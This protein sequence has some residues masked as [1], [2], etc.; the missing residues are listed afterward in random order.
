MTS[1]VHITDNRASTHVALS[2]VDPEPDQTAVEI[3]SLWWLRFQRCPNPRSALIYYMY[4]NGTQGVASVSVSTFHLV[5]VKIY[6]V[7][8]MATLYIRYELTCREMSS[9]KNT[10]H[11]FYGQIQ[12][13]KYSWVIGLNVWK[14]IG[15][16]YRGTHSS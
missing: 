14:K 2:L 4:D 3:D 5:S 7:P 8:Y 1:S 10:T 12:T 11:V 15:C 16:Q 9:N 13:G 6:D